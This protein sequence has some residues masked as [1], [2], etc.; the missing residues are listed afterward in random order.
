MPV[1]EF[2]R[3]FAL[4]NFGP[5]AAD[6]IAALFARIDGTSLPVPSA[7]ID[8][9]GDIVRNRDPWSQVS[10]R[11]DFVG[12]M[13]ALR[14]R[15][16]GAA[17]LER[18]DYWLNQFRAFRT[19]GELGCTAGALDRE[20][21]VLQAMADGGARKQRARQ[22]ALTLRVHLAELWTRLLRYEIAGAGSSGELGTIANLEQRSRVHQ[23]LLEKHDQFLAAA[24]G[25]VLPDTA[26]PSKSYAGPARIVVPTLRTSAGPG[27]DVRLRVLLIANTPPGGAVVCWRCVGETEYRRIPL[28]HISRWANEAV[29][30]PLNAKAPI[31]EYHIEATLDGRA[32]RWPASDSG[33]DQTMVLSE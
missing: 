11:Y 31:A 20:V 33:R 5:E 4:A 17:N 23:K 1:E 12:E 6:P 3:D 25:E 10:T 26:V 27:E 18:Y 21:E 30:P 7:W 19:I 2:Y 28:R 8:G 9:P 16:R 15:V 13:E 32:E 24:L 22:V 14:V 29:L